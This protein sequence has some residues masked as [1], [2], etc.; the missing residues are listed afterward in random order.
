MFAVL[1]ANERRAL[2]GSAISDMSSFREDSML[3][4]RMDPD[5]LYLLRDERI[6]LMRIGAS[7][8]AAAIDSVI[9]KVIEDTIDTKPDGQL[10]KREGYGRLPGIEGMA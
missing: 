9:H 10:P 6:M 4:G 8:T 2:I 1:L 3:S 7:R 5:T